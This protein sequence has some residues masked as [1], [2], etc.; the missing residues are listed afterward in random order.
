MSDLLDFSALERT[1]K[2]ND[3]V[4]APPGLTPVEPDRDSP[5]FD[6]EPA[7]VAAAMKAVVE[8]DVR[9]AIVGISDDSLA[10]E[11]TQTSLIFGFVDDISIRALEGGQVA[12]YSRSRTGYSDL[13]VN[14]AR[15]DRWLDAL[16]TRLGS[17]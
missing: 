6:A 5:V 8:A 17:R 1:G 13:G 10:F 9:T 3:Y 2:P 15:V 14:Q 12:I 4:V 16:A 11:A 7:A